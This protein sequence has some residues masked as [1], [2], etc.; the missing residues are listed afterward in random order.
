M[1]HEGHVTYR[2]QPESLATMTDCLFP[3]NEDY[4]LTFTSLGRS[5]VPQLSGKWHLQ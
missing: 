5:S 4:K 3:Q 2:G 1:M